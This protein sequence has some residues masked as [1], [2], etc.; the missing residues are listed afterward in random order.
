MQLIADYLGGNVQN[1]IRS[2]KGMYR[3]DVNPE[4]RL[5]R[6]LAESFYAYESHSD[7]VVDLFPGALLSASNNYDNNIA[8]QGFEFEN[9][10][11]VQFH[12]EF[13][14]SVLERIAEKDSKS[15][16][17]IMRNECDADR[18]LQIINNYLNIIEGLNT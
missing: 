5:L 3:I 2:E 17:E 15:L 7:F 6:N 12:P 14:R 8:I 9:F 11:C 10:Y 4:S 1:N 13:H 16:I 18:P